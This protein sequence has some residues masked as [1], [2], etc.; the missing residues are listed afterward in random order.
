MAL[1]FNSGMSGEI[2]ASDPDF[3]GIVGTARTGEAAERDFERRKAGT[4]HVRR[5]TAVQAT[6]DRLLIDVVGADPERREEITEIQRMLDDFI[7]ELRKD[8]RYFDPDFDA[9]SETVQPRSMSRRPTDGRSTDGR[10]TK[11]RRGES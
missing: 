7:G 11:R 4:W 10:A 6:I 9:A 3:P 5:V 2:R 1:Q 8:G